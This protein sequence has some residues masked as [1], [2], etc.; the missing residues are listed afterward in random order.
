MEPMVAAAESHEPFVTLLTC[1]RCGS[2]IPD[3][4]NHG[5]ER[6]PACG[7]CYQAERDAEWETWWLETEAA[8]A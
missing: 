7:T 4:Q 8:R 6:R 5:S 2:L 3:G 1:S